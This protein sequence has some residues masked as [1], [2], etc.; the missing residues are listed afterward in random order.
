MSNFA[1]LTPLLAPKTIAVLGASSDPTRIGGRPIAYMLAQK[2]P[3]TL[4]PVNPNRAE[5][6]GL[7]AYPTVADLPETPDVAI[8][9]VPS[10]LAPQAIADL[11]AKGCKGVIMFTAGFA[12]VDDAGAAVQAGMVETARRHGMRLLGP[13]CLGVF[14]AG[15]SYYA[16]FSS[17]FDS[18]WPVPGR[19]GI[20]SQSGAYGT[21]LYTLARNRHI[22]ASLCVMTGNEADVTVGECIGWLAENPEVDVIA[23]YAEGIRE[24]KTLIAALQAARAAR[25]PV[26]MQKVG[27]S[28]L[29]GKAAKSHT[30]S[31]AGDDAV[32]E[33]VMKE[34]GVYR[35]RNSEEMLD[36]AHT[37]TRRIYPVSNTLGVIT[38][39]GGAGVL[40]SD[41]ADSLGL[42]MPEMPQAAQDKLRALVPFCG[43]RNP[44]DATA[45]V[46]NNV[47][48]VKTFMDTMVVEGR[49]ASVLGFFSM[50]ASSRRWPK[51]KEQLDRTKAENPGRLYALS[52][53]VPPERRDEL[54]ADGWVVHE[55]PTRAVT[56]IEAMG[57]F[58]AAFAAPKPASAPSVPPVVLPHATPSE[59]EAKRLLAAAG[60]A[61]APEAACATA[62]EAVAAAERFGYP[63]VMKI[64]SPDILHKSEIGGVLLDVAGA[65]AVLSGF[66]TLLDRARAA[67]PNARIEGVL[68]A[69]QLKGGVECIL[70]IHRDPVFGPMA[71]FG[72]GGIFV[73]VLKDV[74]FRRCPFGP[75]VAETMIR[76]I[77]GAPLL[78]GARGRPKADIK[79]LAEMLSRLSAFA[80]AAGDRLQSVDLN[81]VFAMPEG[82]GAFAVDA[83]I[84]VAGGH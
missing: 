4:Y 68:V 76:S 72:L 80:A 27:R 67:A 54:E 59:A 32:T 12:E 10:E 33:A 55:D 48:L 63:V 16:T 74:V 64:L 58:G 75:D 82:Q 49:Y 1:G 29:G 71:M 19:I 79:A 22:G 40:I 44:V 14:D 36:I 21:H 38:V 24:S 8:V 52:V 81:P 3:G 9:A 37:A 28:E 11:G 26:V 23:V 47:E 13:N 15:R 46:S 34:F 84:E 30:A 43:P 51:I 50:T 45:Q 7:K 20:A 6:Q 5:V 69:K 77:K 42:P 39:S 53:I 78:E 56:A 57:R 2:F 62:D 41:V 73:E 35:A 60:I 66:T 65:P 17:S 61:S 83:V 70:G 18:G 31:I 25:K